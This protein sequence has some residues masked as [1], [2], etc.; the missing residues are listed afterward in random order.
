MSKKK[1][2]GQ[3]WHY[4]L[5]MSK[6]SRTYKSENDNADI[7]SEL[8]K[9]FE[10]GDRSAILKGITFCACGKR[11]FPDWLLKEVV[12]L[13]SMAECREVKSLDNLLG[14][15]HPPGEKLASFERNQSLRDQ[16]Y[17]VVLNAHNIEGAPLTRKSRKKSAFAYAEEYFHRGGITISES[18]VEKIYLA[19]KKKTHQ[20]TLK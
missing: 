2:T 20:Q 8:E 3:K 15:K 14:Y 12:N 10:N 18:R 1:P 13:N 4:T 7:L 9:Q 16:L 5:Q 17:S 11:D 19:E 6:Y